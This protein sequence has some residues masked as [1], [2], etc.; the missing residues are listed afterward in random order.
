MTTDN[1][2]YKRTEEQLRL[3]ESVVGN[4]K[5]AV[6]LTEADPIN[7]PRL[8]F[9]YVNQPLTHIT[10][11]SVEEL[12]SKT[13]VLKA[14]KTNQAI[15][16]QI[17]IALEAWQP[18]QAELINYRKDGSEFWVE[19]NIT[20]VA[21]EKGCYTHW[22]SIERDITERKRTEEERLKF[23]SLVAN[24]SDFI[25]M[26]S[27]EGKVLFVNEAG[28]K[29]VGLDSLEET[30]SKSI[31]D[32]FPDTDLAQF[33][34]TTLPKIMT[35]GQYEAEGQ[36]R[37]FKTGKHI[38]VHRNCFAV[39]HPQSGELI[40]LATVQRDITERKQVEVALQQQA[41]RERLMGII[42]QRIRQSLNLE[43]ILN[44]TVAEVGQF[45]QCDRVLI[46]RFEPDWGGVVEVESVAPAWPSILGT[47]IKDSYFLETCSQN[48]YK[49]GRIQATADIYT[50]GL[51]QCHTDLLA[52]RQIRGNLVVPI[53]QGEKLWGLLIANQC[54]GPRQWQQL[55]IDLLKQLATQVG[56]AIQQSEIYQQLQA[57]N[58]ELQRLASLDSLTQI[59]N[60]RR[61]EEYLDQEWRR[62]AREGAPLSLILCDID[63]FKTYNDTYG[64]L[65]GDECLRQVA[66]AISHAVERPADLVARYGGEEFAVI[67]PNTKAE[68]AIQV[69]E[70]IRSKVQALRIA[71]TSSQL[72]QHVTLSL[73]VAS[74]V[75]GDDFSTILVAAADRALY[76]A[77]AKGRDAVKLAP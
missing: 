28:R 63:F 66:K 19:L 67:L 9:L 24:S 29:L 23:V 39:R 48:L 65:A 61:F 7:E 77:K 45:L 50:A 30:L 52:Q 76:Q 5:D 2:E 20:P 17:R 73:G 4:A 12:L 70:K 32:Y 49:E 58:Q 31:A 8:Q 21:D 35:T 53:L 36:L 37:H 47:K 26:P 1:N 14:V 6:V 51:S 71:H 75:P 42:A 68:K 55:E 25:A 74:I 40:C 18:V 10:A 22:I 16:D 15:L 62:M 33:Y 69:A 57:A 34:E 27:L 11:Y 56:I 43:E 54:S 59:A 46:Y 72:R 3:L 44:T 13:Q 64:H 38:D 60:R 41:L